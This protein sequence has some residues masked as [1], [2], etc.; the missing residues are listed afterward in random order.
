MTEEGILKPALIGGV[1]LGIL[2]SLPVIGAFNCCCCAWVIG[3]G[4]LA[5]S[6]YVKDSPSAVTLGRGI[7]LGLLTGIIG[8]LVDTAFSIPLL[9]FMKKFG[10]DLLMQMQQTIDKVP[11]LPP[12]LRA[13]LHSM[14]TSEGMNV[15]MH[16]VNFLF[17]LVVYGLMAMLGGAIGVAIFEKRIPG[18]VSPGP[19]N[20][21]PVNL[22]PPPP[23]DSP[24]VS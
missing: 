18:A 5:A 21:P 16:V 24:P 22:P 7:T 1:L 19:V 9:L 12:D 15:V 11:N 13:Q 3:G 6:I 23:P 17:K 14:I 2:S 20:R 10:Q 4:V 8:A